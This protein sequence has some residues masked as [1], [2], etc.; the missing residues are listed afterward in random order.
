MTREVHNCNK[1]PVHGNEDPAQPKIKLTNLKKK[2][3][4]SSYPDS[5]YLSFLTCKMKEIT[6][7]PS[8]KEEE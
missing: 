3:P 1:S 4:Q 7:T 5:L 6:P 8:G 2:E